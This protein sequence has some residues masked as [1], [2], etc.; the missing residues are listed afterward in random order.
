MDLTLGEKNSPSCC[1]VRL[2]FD[3]QLNKY[4]SVWKQSGHKRFSRLWSFIC[5][6]TVD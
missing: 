6:V 1:S 3:L 5:E 2:I 4:T